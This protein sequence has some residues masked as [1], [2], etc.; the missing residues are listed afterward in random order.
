MKR[1]DLRLPI[2]YVLPNGV[3]RETLIGATS[4]Q[5]QNEQSLV[6]KV[7]DLEN[8]D[9]RAAFKNVSMDMRNYQKIKMFV[10]AEEINEGTLN[11]GDVSVFLRLGSDYTTNFYE[12]EIPMKL[13]NWG[14]SD[15]ELN[16]ALENEFDIPFELFQS[17]K[18][19]RNN[20]LNDSKY[21]KL[22][23][24]MIYLNIFDGGNKVSI[25]RKS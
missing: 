5:Q 7:I 22:I 24:I 3:E 14:E 1:T 13:T 23:V 20:V 15:A 18:Q 10:H 25:L 17:V 12:Y 19:I 8:G 16:L 6:L 4:L 2:N 9:A 11:D 21:I